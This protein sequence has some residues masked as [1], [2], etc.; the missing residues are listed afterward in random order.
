[1][2]IAAPATGAAICRVDAPLGAGD[3]GIPRVTGPAGFRYDGFM[4][5]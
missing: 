5:G 2:P 1:M 4:K 3:L